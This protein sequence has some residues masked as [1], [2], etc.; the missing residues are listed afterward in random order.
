MFKSNPYLKI[1]FLPDGKKLITAKITKN[2]D[3]QSVSD[4]INGLIVRDSLDCILDVIV[5]SSNKAK[6][7]SIGSY[8]YNSIVSFQKNIHIKY[9][10]PGNRN[11]VIKPSHVMKMGEENE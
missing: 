6:V 5:E 2:T 8:I 11:P 10:V 1:E 9:W 4:F 3:P 7:P